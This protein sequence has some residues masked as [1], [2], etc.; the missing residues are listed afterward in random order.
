MIDIADFAILAPVPLEHLQTGK[1]VADAKGFVAFGS[2]KWELFRK[3]DEKRH[4]LRVP[5]II[6]PSHE[7]VPSK[8][9]FMVTWFGW[10]IAY[11]DSVGG[12]HPFG[13]T[14]RPPTTNKYDSDNSGHWAVFWHVEGLRELP[15]NLYLP[16][17][18]IET[19][20]E[21]WRKNAPP[22]GP[23]LVAIPPKLLNLAQTRDV[24]PN[25]PRSVATADRSA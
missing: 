10:Y 16:I 23:E 13:M 3:V 8:L 9:T 15:K 1:Q 11:M 14:H 7:G 24:E 20:K 25:P 19:V 2:K 4:G 17:S 6:Y 21:G 18:K 22:R 12:A 5:T